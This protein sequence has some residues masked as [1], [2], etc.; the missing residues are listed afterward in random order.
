MKADDIKCLSED[1]VN[2]LLASNDDLALAGKASKDSID[3]LTRQIRAI[4]SFV[5]KKLKLTDS[6]KNLLT[7]PGIGKILG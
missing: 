4:E 2:R 1:R 5:E 3:F 7:V 6:Y